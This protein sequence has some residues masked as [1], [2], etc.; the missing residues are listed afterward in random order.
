MAKKKV[1][2]TAKAKIKR[3]EIL[4]F[5]FK[6]NK[7]NLYSIKLNRLINERIRLLNDY[8]EL[9]I[10][11]SFE[12]TRVTF[13]EHYMLFYEIKDKEI[14]IH[15]LWDSRQDSEKLAF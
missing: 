1:V 5:Y 12:G 15:L 10:S 3:F 14:I 6:R 4:N 8:P 2:W 13:I 11:T 7:S 9:G